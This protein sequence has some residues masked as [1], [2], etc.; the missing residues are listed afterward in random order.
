MRKGITPVVAT[1]LLIM[2]TVTAAGT[3]YV[4][5]MDTQREATEGVST[6]EIGVS[7]V[8]SLEVESCWNADVATILSV[9]NGGTEA[10]NASKLNVYL[11][12]VPSEVEVK[13]A[14]A[15]PDDLF[16]V[17]L[18]KK[19]SRDTS[20]KFTHGG[21]TKTHLCSNLPKYPYWWDASW[22]YKKPIKIQENSGN[23]LENYQVNLDIDT[24]SLIDQN[25]MQSN[26]QDM[27]F[28][29][30]MKEIDHWTKSGCNT[31]STDVWVEVPEIPA[32]GQKE[33]H[34]YYGN[35]SAPSTSSPEETMYLYDL[36]GGG[37]DSSANLIDHAKYNSSGEFVELTNLTHDGRLNYTKGTPSPGFVANWSYWAGGGSGADATWLYAWA[38]EPIK[39]EHPDS[40]G[41]TFS[42]DEYKTNEIGIGSN[43]T[44][45]SNEYYL[46]SET[47][48]D[49]DDSNWHS[50]DLEAV[51]S[52]TF[53][54]AEFRSLGQN[55][56]TF[57]GSSI[58]PPP[59]EMFGFGSRIGVDNNTHRISNITVRK[60]T[61]ILPTY[62][63]ESEEE[64]D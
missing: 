63:V 9:R 16:R 42:A 35:P 58:L 26:C 20:I 12:G 33:I 56:G 1:I 34:M 7:N 45:N 47:V 38:T 29:A 43:G 23:N 4:T 59:G 13:S 55:V 51:T 24:K 3:V 17:N 64:K 50:A 18:T 44:S 15:E 27:R 40:K 25:K 22:D 28:T 32:N 41:Y 52:G 8:G 46:G 48:A 31:A 6:D 5:I 54:A 10:I 53:V 2:I 37:L 57:L 39:L 19:I 14:V 11:G 49:I 21:E 60:H 62:T 36:H 61:D 30:D